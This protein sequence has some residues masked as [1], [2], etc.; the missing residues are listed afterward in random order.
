MFERLIKRSGIGSL[1]GLRPYGDGIQSYRRKKHLSGFTLIELLVVV[2]IIALLVS[3]LLP[4]LANARNQARLAVCSNNYRQIGLAIQ[5][6]VGDN[7][8]CLPYYTYPDGRE[9]GSTWEAIGLMV[10]LNTY[11]S[12]TSQ[13]WDCP[14]DRDKAGERWWSTE[15]SDLMT[16]Y[17]NHNV[18]FRMRD[19]GTCRA[20]PLPPYD[21]NYGANPYLFSPNVKYCGL[22]MG[23][24]RYNKP[25][26]IDKVEHPLEVW[27][28]FH[29]CWPPYLHMGICTLAYVDGH[30]SKERPPGGEAEVDDWFFSVLDARAQNIFD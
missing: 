22:Y 8:D 15:T 27:T 25:I 2:S 7:R 16:G 1:T 13:V 3:I 5:M 18:Y 6:Y 28:L 4:S 11:I 14:S 20:D 12:V 30:V 26:K 19:D 29:Y 17:R 23:D 10:P 21:T 24:N 9:L